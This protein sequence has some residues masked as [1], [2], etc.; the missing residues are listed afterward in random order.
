MLSVVINENSYNRSQLIWL[1][2]Y[3]YYYNW[4]TVHLEFYHKNNK[5]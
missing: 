4:S 5:F 1:N 2:I 3:Y